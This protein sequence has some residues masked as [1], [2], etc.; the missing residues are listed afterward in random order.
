MNAPNGEAPI[1][2]RGWKEICRFLNV[3]N[4]RT[5]RR[6]LAN[7]ELLAYEGK[8]PVLNRSCYVQAS[9]A[10]HDPRRR[11]LMEVFDK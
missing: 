6:I 10:R 5:A 7:M 1:E 3:R 4:K 9:L 2:L 8:S 11:F